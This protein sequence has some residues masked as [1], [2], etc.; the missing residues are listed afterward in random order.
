MWLQQLFGFTLAGTLP[1]WRTCCFAVFFLVDCARAQGSVVPSLL[2]QALTFP[3]GSAGFL[4]R[5]LIELGLRDFNEVF[6][7]DSCFLVFNWIFRGI[8][9]LFLAPAEV[10]DGWCGC[11]NSLCS[12]SL[13]LCRMKHVFRFA[14]CLLC[15]GWQRSPGFPPCLED[16]IPVV[17]LCSVR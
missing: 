17:E 11:S 7:P 9:V 3:R 12:R 5:L 10:G 1:L 16:Q 4:T 15:F 14:F 8:F 2:S 13:V 6:A